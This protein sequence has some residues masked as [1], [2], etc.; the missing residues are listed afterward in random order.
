MKKDHLFLVFLL[1][2][3]VGAGVRLWLVPSMRP[4]QSDHTTIAKGKL[5]PAVRSAAGMAEI[6]ELRKR[7]K[8]LEAQIAELEKV[9]EPVGRTVA[10]GNDLF[11]GTS[12]SVYTENPKVRSARTFGEAR[13]LDPE[14]QA[15]SRHLR[16]FANSKK[17]VKQWLDKYKSYIG[18]FDLSGLSDNEK[19]AHERFLAAAVKREAALA[20]CRIEDDD[21][22]FEEHARNMFE[23]CD[24]WRDAVEELKSETSIL[25]GLAIEKCARERGF[26]DADAAAIAEAYR[27]IYE[28]TTVVF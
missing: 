12:R 22:T 15:Q 26:I 1:A 7:Q 17:C 3:A 6:A 20:K 14:S 9:E 4:A 2:F 8:E 10:S 16:M 25:M 23:F 13:K 21:Y 19:D 11:F 27:A 18:G 28:A 5:P 24:H